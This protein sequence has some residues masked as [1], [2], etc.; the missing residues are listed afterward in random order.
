MENQFDLKQ[1][2]ATIGRLRENTEALLQAAEDIPAVQ[3]NCVR[4]L[5]SIKMLEINVCD[6]VTILSDPN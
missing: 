4:M 1:M 3:R 2:A 6:A 5:A